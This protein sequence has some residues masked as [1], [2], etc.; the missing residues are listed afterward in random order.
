MRAVTHHTLGLEGRRIGAGMNNT[1]GKG[2]REWKGLS[3]RAG[4]DGRCGRRRGMIE[5]LESRV[6]LAACV[7]RPDGSCD[8]PGGDQCG[9]GGRGHQRGRRDLR[10]SGDGEQ[11]ATL[12]GLRAGVDARSNARQR[13]G[14]RW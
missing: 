7:R 2:P 9:A 13:R 3:A 4:G 12:N 5:S 11:Q 8:N 1:R 14:D 10:G 6:L